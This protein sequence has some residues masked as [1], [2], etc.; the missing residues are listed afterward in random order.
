MTFSP[1]C[2]HL[3]RFAVLLLDLFVESETFPCVFKIKISAGGGAGVF[4]LAD[5]MGA[6]EIA[7]V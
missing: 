1:S 5:T 4:F 2:L 6:A 3:L 7:E